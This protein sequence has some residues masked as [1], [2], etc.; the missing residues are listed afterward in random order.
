ML[1]DSALQFRAIRYHRKKHDVPLASLKRPR[2]SA[3]EFP[4]PQFGRIASLGDHRIDMLCLLAAEKRYD[5]DGAVSEHLIG[6]DSADLICD[7]LRFILV[8]IMRIAHPAFHVNID[9]GRLDALGSSRDS[10]WQNLVL[11]ERP[12]RVRDDWWHATEVFT[13]HHLVS[14]KDTCG[15]I[16]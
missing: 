15:Q 6:E 1:P 10:E 7:C 3:K 8:A 11:I 9:Q 14:S 12:I 4:P 13:E 2:V 16:I 5:A